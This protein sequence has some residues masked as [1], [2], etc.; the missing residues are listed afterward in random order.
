[1]EDMV[2]A[3]NDALAEQVAP[4]SVFVVL[5]IIILLVL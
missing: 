1:M 2:A 5:V 4:V 3:G